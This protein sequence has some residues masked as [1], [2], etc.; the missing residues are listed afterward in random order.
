LNGIICDFCNGTEAS[1]ALDCDNLAAIASGA[2]GTAVAALPG[3]WNACDDCLPYIQRGDPDGL[4]NYVTMAANGPPELLR[5]TS[6]AFRRDVFRQLYKRVL[7]QLGSPRPLREAV[8][9]G[10]D[11]WPQLGGER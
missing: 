6:E 11:K 9:V 1:W 8:G 4:A 2:H 7:P 5:M 3:A 10:G